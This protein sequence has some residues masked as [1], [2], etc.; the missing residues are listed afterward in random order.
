MK[1]DRVLRAVDVLAACI[2][3]G[4]DNV[5]ALC[6]AG[7]S[8]AEARVIADAFPEA[9]AA[10]AVESLG[11][12]ISD[13]S[14]AR[15]SAGQW[16]P[17]SLDHCSIYRA[18]VDMAREHRTVGTLEQGAYFAIAEQSA[19]IDAVSKALNAGENVKGAQF[20]VTFLGARIEDLSAFPEY[21]RLRRRNAG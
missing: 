7:F 13:T 15:N 20:S 6:A 17:F 19:I 10:P 18:A 12:V 3:D 16:M 11:V 2:A 9:F 14:S 4:T 21:A 1:R 5:A 8:A